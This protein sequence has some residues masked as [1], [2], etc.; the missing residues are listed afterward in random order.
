MTNLVV[1]IS[2]YLIILLIAVYTYYNFRFF[3]K[4]DE[5]GKRQACRR[6]L[7]CLFMLHFLANLVIYANTES[8][9]LAAFYGA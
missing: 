8:A 9:E 7:V 1:G 4:K 6:Q 2:R 5:A 3:A